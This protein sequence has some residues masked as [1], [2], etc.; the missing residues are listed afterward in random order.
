[1]ENQN[2]ILIAGSFGHLSSNG[3]LKPF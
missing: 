3:I 1:M 2:C